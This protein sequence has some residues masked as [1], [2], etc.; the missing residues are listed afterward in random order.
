MKGRKE[1]DKAGIGVNSNVIVCLTS[2][3]AMMHTLSKV[4][5]TKHFKKKKNNLFIILYR[6]LLNYY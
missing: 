5:N 3:I 1:T 6:I 2:S 4:I